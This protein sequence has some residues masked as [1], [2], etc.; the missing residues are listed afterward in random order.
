MDSSGTKKTKIIKNK[1]FGYYRLL[2][3]YQENLINYFTDIKRRTDA[4]KRK[5]YQLFR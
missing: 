3:K 5:N 2:A 4:F 1:I